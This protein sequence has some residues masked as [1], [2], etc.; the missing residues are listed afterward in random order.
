MTAKAQLAIRPPAFLHRPRV[1]IDPQ[2]LRTAARTERPR[3][4][5]HTCPAAKV[6]YVAGRWSAGLE[7]ADDVRNGQEVKGAIEQ[8]ERRT[9][10]GRPE[11]G[12]RRKLL[13]ALHIRGGQCPKRPRNLGDPELG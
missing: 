3:G 5:T 2:E 1:A 7:R 12:S 11:S 9:L 8:R 4:A 13:T 10:S 6:E